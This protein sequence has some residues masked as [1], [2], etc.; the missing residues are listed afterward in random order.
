MDYVTVE[1]IPSEYNGTEI[2]NAAKEI[3]SGAMKINNINHKLNM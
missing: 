3:T 1:Y 2:L